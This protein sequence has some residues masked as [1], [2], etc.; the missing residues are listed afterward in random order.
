MPHAFHHWLHGSSASSCLGEVQDIQALAQP[1]TQATNGSPMFGHA[2]P[3]Y[4]NH[5]LCNKCPSND[6]CRYSFQRVNNEASHPGLLA[7]DIDNYINIPSYAERWHSQAYAK[8]STRPL[9]DALTVTRGQSLFDPHT[10]MLHP[11]HTPWGP[12]ANSN[13][14]LQEPLSQGN[15]TFASERDFQTLHSKLNEVEHAFQPDRRREHHGNLTNNYSMLIPSQHTSGSYQLIL[16]KRWNAP[17]AANQ[18]IMSTGPA[19]QQDTVDTPPQMHSSVK[20]HSLKESPI[21]HSSGMVQVSRNACQPRANTRP[22]P[23]T[24]QRNTPRKDKDQNR[25]LSSYKFNHFS[26]NTLW[27]FSPSLTQN[28]QTRSL[29]SASEDTVLCNSVKPEDECRSSQDLHTEKLVYYTSNPKC[30]MKSRTSPVPENEST[31][32]GQ[33]LEGESE[34][35]VLGR[36]SNIRVKPAG[37]VNTSSTTCRSSLESHTEK[38]VH[39]TIDQKCSL[40]LRTLPVPEIVPIAQGPS[41]RSESEGVML[42]RHVNVSVNPE[43]ECTSPSGALPVQEVFMVENRPSSTSEPCP[44]D[45]QAEGDPAIIMLQGSHS[46]HAREE[47]NDPN[48]VLKKLQQSPGNN[49]SSCTESEVH[50]KSSEEF[51]FSC[52]LCSERLISIRMYM[53]HIHKH[54]RKSKRKRHDQ[55]LTC[56][57]C[58]K[59]IRCK[60]SQKF[61]RHL[62]SHSGDFP[63]KCGWCDFGCHRRTTLFQHE[64]K[65]RAVK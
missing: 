63:Y 61:R 45:F 7:G 13:P 3:Q 49:S 2:M 4:L 52:Q 31:D 5:Q 30:A 55:I 39:N 9:H 8:S 51:P 18:G 64:K 29:E 11:F 19:N 50:T 22:S 60:R 65:C 26:T 56:P 23:F 21:S 44:H 25:D 35:V 32:E 36:H 46:A 41:L 53:I 43:N 1:F 48:E 62:V 54:F 10:G 33:S 42:G 59:T 17:K 47:D 37:G 28:A 6:N 27:E 58:H 40:E 34:D 14:L 38:L 57:V 12:Y 20:A 24:Q 15:Q 16:H